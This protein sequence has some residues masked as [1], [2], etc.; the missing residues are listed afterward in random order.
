MGLE[1]STLAAIATGTSA[2]VGI[3]GNIQSRNA[4]K[5]GKAE[6]MAM[7][8]AQELE[9]RRRQ[10]REERIKRARILQ[11]S[12][13]TGTAGSS[14]EAGAM[15]SLSTQLSAN[16][17]M[18]L[19][20]AASGAAITKYNQQAADAAGM[21][22]TATALGQMVPTGARLANSIFQTN[23]AELQGPLINQQFPNQ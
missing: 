4:Q 6:Q 9:E 20:L 13:N 22:Q 15:S 16:V 10:F 1:V 19:G 5:K 21:A 18:N 7:N 2:A 12:E 23:G 3:V 17:G 8:K 14:G 11:M